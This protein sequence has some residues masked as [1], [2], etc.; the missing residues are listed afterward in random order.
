M[1]YNPC[2][3]RITTT[4]AAN[5]IETVLPINWYTN[6]INGNDLHYLGGNNRLNNAGDHDDLTCKPP[7]LTPTNSGS[8]NESDYSA[9]T[10]GIP[11]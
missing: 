8:E 10:T 1:L 11:S 7:L 9:F 5:F 6:L 2:T 3:E 4:N